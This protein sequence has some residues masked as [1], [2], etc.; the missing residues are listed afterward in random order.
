MK[1]SQDTNTKK[2]FQELS[3]QEQV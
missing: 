2:K 3:L 1:I